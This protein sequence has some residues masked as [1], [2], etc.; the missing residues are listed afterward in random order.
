MIFFI[1]F[2]FHIY[3][4]FIKLVLWINSVRS[5]CISQD[6]VA[7]IFN[8]NP[9]IARYYAETE[10]VVSDLIEQIKTCY[11]ISDPVAQKFVERK[12]VFH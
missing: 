5:I 8:A 6:A 1:P 10:S 7:K 3:E 2:I 11:T 9:Q 4:F 12:N